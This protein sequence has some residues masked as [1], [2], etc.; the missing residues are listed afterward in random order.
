M[1]TLNQRYAVAG[2]ALALVAPLALYLNYSAP[3]SA[4][5]QAIGSAIP[6]RL[7]KW[8][9]E[10]PDRGGTKE[11]EEILQTDSIFTRTYGCGA[12]LSCD[13]TI[14]SAQDNPNAV[15]PPELCYTGS[16][17]TETLKDT[18]AVRVGGSERVVNRRQFVRGG[19]THLWM[20]YWYKAGAISTPSYL[21]FQ[22]EALKA[23]LVR[24]GCSCSLVQ[25]RAEFSKADFEGEVLAE[26]IKFAAEVMPAVDVA[27]P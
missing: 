21:G 4:D 26:L 11:E 13:L 12:L 1:R 22:W 6:R 25:V 14:V 5:L 16:G 15:H 9:A 24:S 2:V 23:R 20:L 8:V 18:I 3:P 10:G 7:G 27:I 19:G 17:W